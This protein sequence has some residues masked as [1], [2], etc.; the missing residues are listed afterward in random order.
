MKKILLFLLIATSLSLFSCR[1]DFPADK[2]NFVGI[3]EGDYT[4]L[5]IEADGSGSYIY[6]DGFVN[7][8][9]TGGKVKITDK[10]LS[11]HL[12]IFKKKYKID[13][14]P[15]ADSNGYIIMTLDGEDFY[16]F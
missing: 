9:I 4:E 14:E 5:T 13:K 8:Y 1:K 12:G 7:K 15:F 16:K 3:W 2:L 11:I 10:Q 6:D